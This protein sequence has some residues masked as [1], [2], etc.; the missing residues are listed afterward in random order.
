MRTSHAHAMK[1]I[2]LK[3]L[4]VCSFFLYSFDSARHDSFR[5]SSQVLFL[6]RFCQRLIIHCLTVVTI[7]TGRTSRTERDS[8]P[9][10]MIVSLVWTPKVT[11]DQ[12]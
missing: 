11:S 12:G 3:H 2:V 6:T 4:C 9:R 7:Y 5:I 1:S 10:T 8:P